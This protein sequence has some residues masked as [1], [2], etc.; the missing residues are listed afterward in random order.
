MSEKCVL[1]GG[2]DI[3]KQNYAGDDHQQGSTFADGDEPVTT[4]T[5]VCD[6][7]FLLSCAFEWEA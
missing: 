2:W 3:T 5:V 7:D 6:L 1:T 4:V